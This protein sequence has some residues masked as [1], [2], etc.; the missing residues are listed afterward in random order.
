[1]ETTHSVGIEVQKRINATIFLRYYLNSRPK[2]MYSVK[3]VFLEIFKIHREK[4]VLKCLFKKIACLRPAALL[5]S[6]SS[7]G[8]FP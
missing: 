1:M 7:K 2:E 8:F 4:P 5:K 6:D 3:R